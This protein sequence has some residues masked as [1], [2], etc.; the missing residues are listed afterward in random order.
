MNIN[1]MYNSSNNCFFKLVCD[2]KNLSKFNLVTT[3]TKD[4]KIDMY[5]ILSDDIEEI[6]KYV[7]NINNRKK[8]YK[9]MI[10]TSNTD[11]TFVLNC[12]EFTSYI[13]YYKND[14]E[15]LVKKIEERCK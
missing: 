10:I 8:P 9:L 1:F 2:I 6:E 11:T 12:L 4:T 7:C 3:I 14:I 15:D 13:S 5:V